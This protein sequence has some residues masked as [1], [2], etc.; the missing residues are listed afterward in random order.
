MTS[1]WHLVSMVLPVT[2]FWEKFS[3]E[4]F[5]VLRL[6]REYYHTNLYTLKCNYIEKIDLYV[7]SILSSNAWGACALKLKIHAVQW[8][9][10]HKL[11]P[12]LS[13][14]PFEGFRYKSTQLCLDIHTQ[15]H[16]QWVCTVVHG[17]VR[18]YCVDRCFAQVWAVQ[19]HSI[20]HSDSK[21]Y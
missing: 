16:L 18:W 1:K 3:D 12:A 8:L 9:A 19:F 21:M 10:M 13:I 6:T 2:F 20:M 14:K 17:K 4:Y 5:C 11:Q 15:Y 7:T